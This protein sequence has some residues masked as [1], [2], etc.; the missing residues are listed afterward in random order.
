MCFKVDSK[1]RANHHP[2]NELFGSVTVALTIF[3]NLIKLEFRIGLAGVS[4][5]WLGQ[6]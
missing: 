6:L 1:T 5:I 4:R 2:S 3:I